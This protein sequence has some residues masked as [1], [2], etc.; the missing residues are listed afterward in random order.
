VE[1]YPV[2]GGR[3][4]GH[5]LKNQHMKNITRGRKGYPRGTEKSAL[6]PQMQV[7]FLGGGQKEDINR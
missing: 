6:A 5:P 4:C 7:V 3:G 1:R 2:E